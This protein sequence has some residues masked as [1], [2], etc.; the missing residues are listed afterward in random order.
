MYILFPTTIELCVKK[1]GWCLF[2][3]KGGSL[4]PAPSCLGNHHH[5]VLLLVEDAA[6]VRDDA[7]LALNRALD[8]GDEAHI[9]PHVAA[10]A[11]GRNKLQ[12][13]R[14]LRHQLESST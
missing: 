4:H 11:L 1:T 10:Q 13:E 5:G 9:H 7:A 8:L 12:V 14:A 2:Q 6:D 3:G